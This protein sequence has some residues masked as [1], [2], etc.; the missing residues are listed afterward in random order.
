MYFFYIHDKKL[1]SMNIIPKKL[2]ENFSKFKSKL[3]IPRKK[4]KSEQFML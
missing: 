4:D 1:S 3:K 2:T